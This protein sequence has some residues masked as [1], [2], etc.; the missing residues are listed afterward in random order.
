MQIVLNQN[1]P[2]LGYKGDVVK[3]KEGYYRNFLLPRGFADICTPTRMK[4]AESRKDKLV[5][6]KQQIMDNAKDVLKKLE[7]LVLKFKVKVTE[8]GTLYAAI[9]E[10]DVLKE[11]KK[12]AH[13]KLEKDQLKM[14]HFKEVGEHKVVVHLGKDLEETV[15][16]AIEAA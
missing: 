10:V 3:V 11:I 6:E 13:V 1:V 16:L 8:K 15:K 9:T 5:M 4:V 2:K 7:G 12:V 14:A